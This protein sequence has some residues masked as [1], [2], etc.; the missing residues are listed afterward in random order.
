MKV[1]VVVFTVEAIPIGVLAG[2]VF[3]SP[4]PRRPRFSLRFAAVVIAML[5]PMLV[6]LFGRLGE[7][8]AGPVVLSGLP[9]GIVVVGLSRFVL[10][11]GSGP[12]PGHRTATMTGRGP[13]TIVPPPPAPIAGFRLPTQHLHRCV[14]ATIA[15][16]RGGAC[17]LVGRFARGS[18]LR[19]GCGGFSHGR[20][21]A[22]AEARLHLPR[23]S[24]VRRD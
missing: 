9:W 21:G 6:A 22:R 13:G 2:G 16:H 23:R 3:A 5:L 24:L 8:T 11:H 17:V 18:V 19:Q 7:Q 14:F 12:D 1:V 15:H 20:S 4:L 10:F